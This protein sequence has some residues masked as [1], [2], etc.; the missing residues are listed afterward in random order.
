MLVPG[1]VSSNVLSTFAPKSNLPGPNLT[2]QEKSIPAPTPPARTT[3][4]MPRPDRPVAPPQRF[5]R[6]Q[7]NASDGD[8]IDVLNAVARDRNLQKKDVPQ[9]DSRPASRI[10]ETDDKP[11]P[12]PPP[13]PK[14]IPLKPVVSVSSASSETN[15]VVPPPRVPLQEKRTDGTQ[16]KHRRAKALYDCEADHDDELEFNE[17]DTILIYG[18]ADPEWLYGEV[19]GKPGRKGVFPINFVHI[20][21]S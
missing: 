5:Q 4:S 11:P 15:P 18:E 3:S 12:L 21:T 20:L 6:H 1:S 2:H 19:E 8:I 13:R 7:R 10:Q 16:A 9:V 17:G 14:G